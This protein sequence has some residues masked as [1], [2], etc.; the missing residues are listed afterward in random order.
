MV[1]A[2]SNSAAAFDACGIVYPLL[3]SHLAPADELNFS[4]CAIYAGKMWLDAPRR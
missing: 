4:D 1:A 2:D 3:S